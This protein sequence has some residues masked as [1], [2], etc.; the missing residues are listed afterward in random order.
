MPGLIHIGRLSGSQFLHRNR[1]LFPLTGV[2]EP[3]VLPGIFL[4]PQFVQADGDKV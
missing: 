1:Q 3:T 2:D 4:F